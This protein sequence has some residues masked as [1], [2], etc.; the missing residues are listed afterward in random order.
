M[1]KIIFIIIVIFLIIGGYFL[2]KENNQPAS[3]ITSQQSNLPAQTIELQKTDKSVQAG[4]AQSD[5]NYEV[6]YTDSGYSP[7]EITIKIGETVTWKNQSSG[8]MWTSSGMHPTHVIYSGS[9]LD[10]HCPDI[11]NVSFDECASAQPGESWSFKFNKE[12][13]W[14]YHNH[15]RAS[16]FGSII[17]E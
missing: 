1:S 2:F 16:D 3:L 4:T 5:K 14:K 9:S 12:G 7:K 13:I 10:E 6:I 15:V 8:G 11:K 17:V